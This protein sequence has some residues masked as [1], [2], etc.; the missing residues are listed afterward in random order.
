MN[1][2]NNSIILKKQWVQQENLHGF[3]SC[4]MTGQMPGAAFRFTTVK[5]ESS[6]H[7]CGYGRAALPL[8]HLL[9]FIRLVVRKLQV[10]DPL[11]EHLCVASE[12]QRL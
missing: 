2:V 3:F 4:N 1:A 7:A 8:H 6:F 5:H 10:K 11:H 9:D 12:V